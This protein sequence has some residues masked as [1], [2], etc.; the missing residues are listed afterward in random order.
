[1]FGFFRIFLCGFG[2]CENGDR[3]F[4]VCSCYRI[5]LSKLQLFEKLSQLL[6]V[7]AFLGEEINLLKNLFAKVFGFGIRSLGVATPG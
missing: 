4:L 7:I 6:D 2:N 5:L 3:N 1:M